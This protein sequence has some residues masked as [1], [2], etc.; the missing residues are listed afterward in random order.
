MAPRLHWWAVK[1]KAHGL[2]S[3]RITQ[4]RTAREACKLAFGRPIGRDTWHA[5][6]LGTRASVLHSDKTRI[7]LLSDPKGWVDL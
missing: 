4:A 2:D 1:P 5:K 3:V 6:D 7:A